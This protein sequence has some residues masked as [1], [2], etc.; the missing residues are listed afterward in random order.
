MPNSPRPTTPDFIREAAN[1]A[2]S[3][4]A[5]ARRAL[6][7][8]ATSQLA[9]QAALYPRSIAAAE[10]AQRAL[11][12]H[13]TAFQAGHLARS[14]Q[15]AAQWQQQISAI[16]R[17]L[18]I[19][20]SLYERVARAS[21]DLLPDNLSGLEA[22]DI[23]SVLKISH[24]DG[25]SLAWAPH[26]DT[27]LAVLA[28][29]TPEQRSTTLTDHRDTVLQD[30]SASLD[31][32]TASD[33]AELRDLLDAAVAAAD[34]GHDEAAQALAGNVLDTTMTDHGSALVR[35]TFPAANYADK[36][37]GKS[38]GFT[39]NAA[40]QQ[41]PL[42]QDLTLFQYVRYLVLAGLSEAFAPSWNAHDGFN[43]H[44]TA[45]EVS[46]ATYRPGFVLPALLLAQALLRLIDQDMT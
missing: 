9:Q 27:V 26:P 38:H 46:R 15:T 36:Q 7:I 21:R 44:R 23:E 35:S 12:T 33:L 13:R 4:S 34:A 10:A 42:S 16:Q 24:S 37:V 20:R 30:V 8:A 17:R 18:T 2:Q 1:R 11:D 39:L 41:Y 5:N 45:H 14:A 25:L 29:T 6:S 40:L 32:I 19:S 43:R 3:I 22:D 28:A 31:Q